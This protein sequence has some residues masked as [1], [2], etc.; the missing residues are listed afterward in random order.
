MIA[1]FQNLTIVRKLLVSFGLLFAAVA[2][3]AGVTIAQLGTFKTVMA[4]RNKVE[5]L[6]DT[7]RSVA[8]E[9]HKERVT[10]LR[11]L[12]TG[13]VEE[14]GRFEAAG[15]STDQ[16]IAIAR[17][18]I[19]ILPQAEQLINDVVELHQTWRTEMAQAQLELMR[20]HLTVNHAR[21][22]EFGGAPTA[23]ALEMESKLA[24][25]EH[26]GMERLRQ[27]N[28]TFEDA[29]WAIEITT[30][31][32][33]LVSLVFAVLCAVVLAHAIA[34]PVRGMTEVMSTLSKG[35]LE[36]TIPC[37]GRRD[38]IGRM[39]DAMEVFRRSLI[40]NREMEAERD[41]EQAAKEHRSHLI[42]TLTQQFQKQSNEVVSEFSNGSTQMRLSA[43]NLSDIA[44]ETSH[45]A[46]AVSS[47]SNLTSASVQTVAAASDEIATSL[48]EA[49]RQVTHA[50]GVTKSAVEAAENTNDVIN[51]L[52]TASERI[53]DVVRLI[54]QIASQTNLLALNATIEAAR[55][56]EAGRGFAV[57]ASEV[58]TLANQTGQATGEIASQISDIQANTGRAVEAVTRIAGQISEINELTV[59][60]AA[61]IEE[62]AVATAEISRSVNQAARSAAE[63][64]HNMSDVRSDAEE[65]GNAAARLLQAAEALSLQSAEMHK[66][67][68]HFLS[69]VRAA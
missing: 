14:V 60:I 63:V 9:I 20:N 67:I 32:G 4:D 47:A 24:E 29:E 25:L 53:G 43:Q 46:D 51:G 61:A 59:S 68:E 11:F 18:L 26:L 50:I 39:A 7:L 13:N 37:L 23:N 5:K 54:E 64:D 2:L 19:D 52:S 33:A 3:T 17:E 57:V 35:H 49:S 38:E 40:H 16:T 65:T 8:I 15:P 21:I 6:H 36:A 62:Q 31:A 22:I 44:R 1:A 30:Y 34:R 69:E 45:R 28:E 27:S 12:S 10:V 55:A 58:K 41:R 56:G 42:E 48:N 66:T